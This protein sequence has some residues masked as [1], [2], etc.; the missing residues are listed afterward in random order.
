L[1]LR[2]PYAQPAVALIVGLLVTAA[3]AVV[4][5]GQYVNNEKQ[6]L[7]LRVRDAGAL[8]S[9][10]VPSSQTPLASTAE[11]ADA[12]GGNAQKFRRFVAAYVGSKPHPFVSMSLWSVTNPGRGPLAVAGLPP[13]LSDSQSRVAPFFARVA[14][15]PTMSVIGLLGSPDPRI[16]YGF[17]TPGVPGGFAVY[18]ESLLPANRESRYQS[19]SAFAGLNYALYLG[20]DAYAP[21][22]LV[23]DQKAGPL[24]GQTA[25]VSVP[26]GDTALTLVMKARGS[27]A[28]ALP[29]DLPWIIAVAG[30]ALTIAAAFATLRLTERRRHAEQLAGRLEVTAAENERLFGEQRDIAQTLQHAL[31]PDVLPQIPGMQASAVY[32]AGEHGVDIGGDWYDVLDVGERRVL[33]VVGDVSGRGLQ[34]ASTMAALRF[35]IHAYAAQNDPPATILRKL[36]GLLDVTDSGQLA[37]IL[38]ALVDLERREITVTSA[39]HLPPLLITDGAARYLKIDVGPPIGVQAGVLYAPTTSELPPSGTLIAYTDG[40]VEIR[41]EDL[42][43]GLA[44]LRE[45]ATGDDGSLSDLLSKL[46]TGLRD[47][48]IEDDTAMVGL[49]WT[50]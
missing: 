36:S 35:A 31:L 5:Q 43:Q 25:S 44:R 34:A 29:E 15:S 45:A 40:L 32:E 50:C 41:G 48:P 21:D 18:G 11:L 13:K 22:L 23:T 47:G 14:T 16:G 49:R 3:L 28:G 46:I 9:E 17:S 26:F 2:Q 8:L 39:G 37:T 6:L 27:L 33:M 24:R 7:R 20:H 1:S 30:L 19:T 4:S 38:C 42:D 12:T 10:A